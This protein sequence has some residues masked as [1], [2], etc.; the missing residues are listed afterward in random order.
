[1]TQ[2]TDPIISAIQ[3]YR[4]GNAAYNAT[5]RDDE[6]TI[7]RTYGPPLDVLQE[8][9]RPAQTREGALEAIR[10]AFETEREFMGES[11]THNMLA[12][13]LAY[14]ENESRQ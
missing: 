5:P 12:A 3:A 8:W 6:E 10:L 11:L 14:F 9:E 1:M 13:A 7:A 4:D 2:I